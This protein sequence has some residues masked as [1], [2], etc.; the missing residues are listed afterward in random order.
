MCREYRHTGVGREIVNDKS[1]EHTWYKM[2]RVGD[3]SYRTQVIRQD[4]SNY[5]IIITIRKPE[6]EV[7]TDDSEYR[8]TSGT[9]PVYGFMR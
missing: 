8:K 3:W 7:K 2:I 9:N 5:S 6:S 1:R 4:V